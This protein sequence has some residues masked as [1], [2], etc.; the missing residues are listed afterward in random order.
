MNNRGSAGTLS[1]NLD[2]LPEVSFEPRLT[3]TYSQAWSVAA[4]NQSFWTG[5]LGISPDHLSS[6][7]KFAPQIPLEMGAVDA[8]V[9]LSQSSLHIQARHNS[10]LWHYALR[11]QSSDQA[12]GRSWTLIFVSSSPDGSAHQAVA[13]LLPGV[14]TLITAIGDE[15][16]ID[17]ARVH[18]NKVREGYLAALGPVQPLVPALDQSPM[19]LRERDF[20]KNVI[21]NGMWQ[22]PA[23]TTR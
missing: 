3:G 9:P 18:T 13:S 6:T 14:T 23:P 10:S 17:G 16:S 15:I 8:I 21:T 22:L 12:V 5:Y 4:F 2:A 1:E 19:C 20:L 7:V 11:L